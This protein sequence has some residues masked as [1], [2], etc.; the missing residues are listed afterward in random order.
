MV[1][2]VSIIHQLKEITMRSLEK[3]VRDILLEAWDPIGITDEPE[4]RNEYDDYVT[5]ICSMIVRGTTII[6]LTDY[7]IE[8]ER[9][10][11]GLTANPQRAEAAAIRLAELG[12]L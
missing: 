6:A 7:L 4:A 11:I 1:Q 5:V 12:K 9:N 3:K 2:E 10:W 8:I